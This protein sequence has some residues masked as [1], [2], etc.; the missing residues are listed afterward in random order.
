MKNFT[1]EE[2]NDQDFNGDI[3]DYFHGKYC[4]EEHTYQIVEATI[5]ELVDLGFR[6]GCCCDFDQ[7][8]LMGHG[9]RKIRTCISHLNHEDKGMCSPDIWVES[10]KEAEDIQNISGLREE[11]LKPGWNYFEDE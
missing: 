5:E 6:L 1:V 4:G 7:L 9:D 10:K 11:Y 8:P 2:A 3:I